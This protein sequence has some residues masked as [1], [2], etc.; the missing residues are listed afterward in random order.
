[1]Q[2]AVPPAE[3]HLS[4]L[5][6]VQDG[7]GGGEATDR[8]ITESV[9]VHTK[10]AH[11]ASCSSAV[12][13]AGNLVCVQVTYGPYKYP[14]HSVTSHVCSCYNVVPI[15]SLQMSKFLVKFSC[16][17][18]G[19]LVAASLIHTAQAAPSGKALDD[20]MSATPSK[21]PKPSG[22]PDSSAK[23]KKAQ[24]KAAD[25]AEEAE[26]LQYQQQLGA[27]GD[28]G[29]GLGAYEAAYGEKGSA[30]LQ[31]MPKTLHIQDAMRILTQEFYKRMPGTKCHNCGCLNPSI[32]KQGSSKVFK[33]YSRRALLQNFTRGIDVA[34]AVTGGAA[35]AVAAMARI[36]EADEAADSDSED[37]ELDDK[38]GAGKAGASAEGGKKRKRA[39]DAGEQAQKKQGLVGEAYEGKSAPVPA[40]IKKQQQEQEDWVSGCCT[41][42]HCLVVELTRPCDEAVCYPRVW[43]F[44]LLLYCTHAPWM[45]HLLP[46]SLTWAAVLLCKLLLSPLLLPQVIADE[47]SE[48][49]EQKGA[50]T[51]AAKAG[52]PVADAGTGKPLSKAKAAEAAVAQQLGRQINL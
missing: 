26:Y 24:Q 19:D 32:K 36:R 51:K 27:D 31:Q 34:A 16:L 40:A 49:E 13:A 1:M 11:N 20:V 29:T 38:K 33:Q 18:R 47:S 42:A 48:E 50:A 45:T 21:P 17:S 22:T 41:L 43:M 37:V 7:Q 30:K 52:S 10:T 5:P 44:M 8:L 39:A 25:D 12:S 46:L 28:L 14:T 9:L 3:A 35:A 2:H 15:S 4:E 23:A 6:P